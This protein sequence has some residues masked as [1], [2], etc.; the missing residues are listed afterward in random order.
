LDN[1]LNR[2]KKA[3]QKQAII[4]ELEEAGVLFHP[5]AEKVGKDF[6]PFDLICHVVYDQP[7]LTRKE[8]AENVKKRNYFTKYGDKAREILNALLDKYADEGIE[9]IEDMN[10][11]R[12]QPINQHGTLV[13]IINIFGGKEKYRQAIYEL[14][15]QLYEVA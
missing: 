10:V 4:N 14:E 8:R 9:N 5:L 7:P 13:E 6:G 3:D 2:W 11:L 15:E 1:F 12:L